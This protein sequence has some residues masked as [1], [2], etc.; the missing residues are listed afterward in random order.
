MRTWLSPTD[1][2]RYV[3]VMSVRFWA[4]QGERRYITSQVVARQPSGTSDPLLMAAVSVTCSPQAGGVANAG[5]TQN[6]LRGSATTMTPR[7][8]YRAP[9]TGMAACVLTASGLRP[10]PSA[11]GYPSSNLWYVAPGSFLA[12]SAPVPRWG[13]TM[14]TDERSRVLDQGEAWAPVRRIVRVGPVREF[15]LVSDHKLTTCAAVGGSRD[16]STQGRELCAGRVDRTGTTVRLVVTAVQRRRTGGSC[17]A[18]Q[19][20]D[21][22]LAWVRASVHHRMVFSKGVVRVSRAPG[23]TREFL[24]TG[25]IR[26]VRGADVLVH[27]PSERTSV[28]VR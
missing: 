11:V 24:V 14:S 18:P 26:H 2:E 12:V 15:E 17:G 19:V 21:D 20:V 27:A 28:L 3:R 1:P 25:T 9:R 22:R 8:V 6:L 10:R 23:C 13:G 4:R 5:A 16:S 7:F